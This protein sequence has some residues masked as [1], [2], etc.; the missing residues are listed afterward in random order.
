[1]S[2]ETELL[3]MLMQM[4][5]PTN[6]LPRQEAIS[7][8]M[9][10]ES[11]IGKSEGVVAIANA[12]SEALGIE[13]PAETVALPQTPSENLNG[14]PVPDRE[15]KTMDLYVMSLGRTLRDAG[16]GVL[17]MDELTSAPAPTGAACQT[18]AQ[19]GKL[20]DFQLPPSV[21]RGFAFNDPDSATAGR[22]LY[23]AESNR[24]CW[25]YWKLDFEEW[26]DFMLGRGGMQAGIRV[27]PKDWERNNIDTAAA[28]TTGFC[29]ARREHWH[30]QPAAH[31]ATRPWPSARSWANS[32]RLLAACLSLGLTHEDRLTTAAIS[33]CVGEEPAFEFLKW[34]KYVDLPDPEVVLADPKNFELPKR[35]DRLRA[36]LDSVSKA[37]CDDAYQGEAFTKRWRA[38]VALLE[39][40]EKRDLVMGSAQYV[41]NK[42]PKGEDYPELA[43][44]FYDVRRTVGLVK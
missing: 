4:G 41:L 8:A 35:E 10:G 9:V 5:L 27:L 1:M 37:G 3:S 33:G 22:P 28:L 11:G 6:G 12:L 40:V 44:T 7:F 39:R 29:R 18:V 17:L 25:V 30:K 34:V 2:I 13:F 21:A 32:T 15:N 42:I 14:I 43:R 31:D 16:Q 26:A 24:P 19:K 20:G 38:V 36:I 23:P